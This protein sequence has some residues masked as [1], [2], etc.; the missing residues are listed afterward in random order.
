MNHTRASDSPVVA[1]LRE[2]FPRTGRPVGVLLGV[3]LVLIW[4]GTALVRAY[5][6]LGSHELAE[7]TQFA[8]LMSV[9]VYCLATPLLL[10]GYSEPS[11]L[12]AQIP[13]YAYRLPL[14]TS[15]LVFWRMLYNLTAIAIFWGTLIFS[16]Y[17]VE[18][19][20]R[21][22]VVYGD[23]LPDFI[24][25]G[26]LIFVLIQTACWFVS[27]YKI[28]YIA[29]P[30]L[31][32]LMF[33]VWDIGEDILSKMTF[34]PLYGWFLV[35]LPIAYVLSVIGVHSRRHG[36]ASLSSV[37]AITISNRVQ[38][39][40]GEFTSPQQAQRWFES[41]RLGRILPVAALISTTIIWVAIGTFRRSGFA[42]VSMEGIIGFTVLI[43]VYGTIVGAV[44][45]GGVFFSKNHCTQTNPNSS[46]FF[47]R[48][49][50]CRDLAVARF[51]AVGKSILFVAVVICAIGSLAL[52]DDFGHGIGNFMEATVAVSDVVMVL[53]I[54]AGFLALVWSLMWF[55][56]MLYALVGVTFCVYLWGMLELIFG[57]RWV[58]TGDENMFMLVGVILWTTM[59]V[60]LH[61]AHKRGLLDGRL[62]GV[63]LAFLTPIA[64][65]IALNSNWI[66]REVISGTTASLALLPLVLAPLATVPL[67][68][69]WARHR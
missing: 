62:L 19:G 68:M 55:G 41:R 32:V 63:G 57:A 21:N 15:A 28:L 46:F 12:R 43:G 47:N 49:M 7:A 53:M 13:V 52:L 1:L 48:P 4:G 38:S 58:T 33:G 3:S 22:A 51:A 59:V 29:I 9:F 6:G 34:L 14:K 18:F 35:S 20:Q 65:G 30:I 42:T 60:L 26:L 31:W 25:G 44:V 54:P 27:N 36:L 61:K 69:H 8:A 37:F 45:S 40:S 11:N 5:Y 23:F 17:Y 50:S 10:W 64:A 66:D 2:Q 56:N 24:W 39:R 67:T 16:V